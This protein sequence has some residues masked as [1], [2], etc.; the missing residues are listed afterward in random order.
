MNFK[1]VR[2]RTK[3]LAELFQFDFKNDSLTIKIKGGRI[4][5]FGYNSISVIKKRK[6]NHNNRG[7]M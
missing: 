7:M 5:L 6:V 3:A 1:E 4:L 2:G